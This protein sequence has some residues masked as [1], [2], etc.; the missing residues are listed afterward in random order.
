MKRVL[1]TGMSGVGKSSVVAELRARGFRAVDTDEGWSEPLP[2]GRQRW[3]EFEIRE[4]LD[5]DD[6]EVLFVAGCEE[7]QTAFYPRFD[8]VILLSAP[9]EVLLERLAQR[10]N[11]P[12]GKSEEQRHRVLTDLDA[13]EPLL[14]R[15][16]DHEILTDVALDDVVRAVLNAVQEESSRRRSAQVGVPVR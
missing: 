5:T 11:N 13:V 15:G 1:L 7:N 10:M 2:D 8:H 9:V 12:Y 14:R 6:A 16:A 3:R 4:L